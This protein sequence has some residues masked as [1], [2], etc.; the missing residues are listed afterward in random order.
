[1]MKILMTVLSIAIFST[2]FA[3][4]EMPLYIL[5]IKEHKFTPDTI[6]VKADRKFRLEV[7][8]D[9]DGSE[10]FESST[11]HIEKI[12]GPKKTIKLVLGPLKKG[13]YPFMGEFHQ[14]TAKGQVIAE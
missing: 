3:Q 10:E 8:N 6:K 2:V 5:V 4:E 9:D 1:M 7:K 13:T 11:L 14:T 12:M